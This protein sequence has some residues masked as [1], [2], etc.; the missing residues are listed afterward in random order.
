ME[1]V[2]KKKDMLKYKNYALACS[3]LEII[4]TQKCNMLCEHCMRGDSVTKQDITEEVLDALFSK[5]CYIDNLALGGGEITLV[6][7]V[8]NLLTQKLKEHKV[9]VHH[10]NFTSNGT[11][12]TN[13]VLNALYNLRE[14]VVSCDKLPRLFEIQEKEV[15]M[16]VCFSL[17]D[18]HLNQILNKN[19][20][21]ETIF[22]NIAKFQLKFGE[23]AIQFRL[24]CDIDVYNE[25]RAKNLPKSVNKIN[26]NKILTHPYPV[27]NLKNK[28]LLIGNI[29]CIS[30]QG[31]V[32]P[33]NMPFDS[34]KAFSFGN[35]KDDELPFILSNMNI[36]ETD[37]DGFNKARN[38]L[39]KSMTA[40]KKSQKK[41][42]PVINKKLELIYRNLDLSLSQMQ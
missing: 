8:I 40:S 30:T 2:K 22:N 12:A 15:P 14:Y 10:V 33:V 1:F 7:E 5:F 41:Y 6:P 31:N 9:T 16:Y 39:L 20:Q 38:N 4:L 37:D 32:I 27:I 18:Y 13:E 23:D 42:I 3:D 35:I 25:G 21:I 24:E 28:A 36:I 29:I 34:E 11:I 17:D 26:M 19:I